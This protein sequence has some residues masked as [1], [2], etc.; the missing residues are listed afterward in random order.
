MGEKYARSSSYGVVPVVAQWLIDAAIYGSVRSMFGCIPRLRNATLLALAVCRDSW[1]IDAA[2]YGSVRVVALGTPSPLSYVC[3]CS[4]R[5]VALTRQ[6]LIV[7][8]S[9]GGLKVLK[10]LKG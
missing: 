7:K 4:L 3:Q 6:M 5:L 9:L 1:L 8:R 10:G 2:I